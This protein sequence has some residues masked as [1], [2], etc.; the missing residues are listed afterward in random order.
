ML[1]ALAEA[2]FAD[3]EA[4]SFHQDWYVANADRYIES[5]LTGTV[6]AGAVLAAQSG[7]AADGVRSYIADYLTR[8]RAPTG[9]L[10]VPMR[11]S[12]AAAGAACLNFRRWRLK[13][14]IALRAS[15]SDFDP[16]RL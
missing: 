11:R 12:L 2:A 14:D 13:A 16:K 6:R 3:A 4:H 15:R 9:E 8:F 1:A 5:I 10:V 7:A